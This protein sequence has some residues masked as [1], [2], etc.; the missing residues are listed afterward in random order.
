[1][2]HDDF[3]FSTPHSFTQL[4]IIFHFHSVTST[5][6][7]YSLMYFI[8]LFDYSLDQLQDMEMIMIPIL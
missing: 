5:L 4:Q 1:M 6:R 2:N 8:R 7:L 3:H